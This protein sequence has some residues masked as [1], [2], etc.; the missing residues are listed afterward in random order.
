[1]LSINC[2]IS[3]NTSK[4]APSGTG[5][6]LVSITGSELILLYESLIS[7]IVNYLVSFLL[8]FVFLVFL[9]FYI[10]DYSSSFSLIYSSFRSTIYSSYI[11]YTIYYSV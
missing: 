8:F 3:F 4:T 2:F 11:G 5:F 7:D 9:V 6:L 1:M 10:V